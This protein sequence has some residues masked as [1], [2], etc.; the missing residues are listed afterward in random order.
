MLIGMIGLVTGLTL[1]NIA[2]YELRVIKFNKDKD[3]MNAYVQRRLE[4][5]HDS[6]TRTN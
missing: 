5:K 6:N 3:I 4:R 1:L 2:F